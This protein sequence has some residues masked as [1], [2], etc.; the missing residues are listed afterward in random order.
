MTVYLFVYCIRPFNFNYFYL[1]IDVQL[2]HIVNCK[3][4]FQ[5]RLF[6][7]FQKICQEKEFYADNIGPYCEVRFSRYS[8]IVHWKSM[9]HGFHVYVVSPSQFSKLCYQVYCVI[10]M[11]LDT[12]ARSFSLCF[13]NVAM[14]DVPVASLCL[15][16]PKLRAI[17]RLRINLLVFS[18]MS[19]LMHLEMMSV[20]RLCMQETASVQIMLLKKRILRRY[21]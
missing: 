4:I 7:M 11:R 21:A 15:Y 19:S 14:D 20:F 17:Y 9:M 18:I 1:I 3:K 12:V 10:Q 16:I 6:S 8:L 2:Y 5:S 13:I